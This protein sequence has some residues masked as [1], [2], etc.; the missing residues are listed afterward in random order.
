M[1]SDCA[2]VYYISCLSGSV[3]RLLWCTYV[4]FVIARTVDGS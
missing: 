3:A 1:S 4:C 2:I